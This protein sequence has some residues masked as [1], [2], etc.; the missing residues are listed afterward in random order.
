MSTAVITFTKQ[1]DELPAV[2]PAFPADE[3]VAYLAGNQKSNFDIFLNRLAFLII[4]AMLVIIG[5]AMVFKNPML[6]IPAGLIALTYFAYGN[7]K[8]PAKSRKR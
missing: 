7:M 6:L 5:A 1:Q 4:K 8:K 3:E 2:L